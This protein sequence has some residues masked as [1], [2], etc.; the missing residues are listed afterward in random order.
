[1]ISNGIG[2]QA[3]SRRGWDA[4][5]VRGCAEVGLW[6]LSVE[7]MAISVTRS[8]AFSYACTHLDA[9]SPCLPACRRCS[10]VGTMVMPE[11]P[12]ARQ[13]AACMQRNDVTT[14]SMGM[15]SWQQIRAIASSLSGRL[16]GCKLLPPS[17]CAGHYLHDS[18]SVVEEVIGIGSGHLWLCQPAV[19]IEDQAEIKGFEPRFESCGHGDLHAAQ[20]IHCCGS[21]HIKASWGAG[22][23]L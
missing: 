20:F 14:D 1:M 11:T 9:T 18:Q 23:R 15:L 7:Q 19:S 17:E 4:S 16:V 13:A 3:A 12:A 5:C 10:L 22:F 2:A 6:I 8:V 21:A